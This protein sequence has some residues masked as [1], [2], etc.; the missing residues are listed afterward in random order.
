MEL[1]NSQMVSLHGE[2]VVVMAPAR[3]MTKKQALTHAAW[4]VAVSAAIDDPQCDSFE[5]ILHQVEST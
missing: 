3:A 4:L 2:R 5:S 1:M